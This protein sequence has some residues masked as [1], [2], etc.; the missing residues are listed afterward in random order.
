MKLYDYLWAISAPNLI[1]A[2]LDKISI[3][4]KIDLVKWFSY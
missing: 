4:R 1:G 3:N 2:I